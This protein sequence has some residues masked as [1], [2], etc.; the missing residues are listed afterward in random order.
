MCRRRR[1]CRRRPRSR[2]RR[3]TRC[4]RPRRSG[5]ARLRAGLSPAVE[6]RPVGGEANDPIRAVRDVDRAVR[7]HRDG[8]DRGEPRPTARRGAQLAPERAVRAEDLDRVRVLVGDVDRPVRPDGDGLGKAQ[9]A[10][11]SAGR[12]SPRRRTGTDRHP[13]SPRRPPARRAR[14]RTVRSATRSG[15]GGASVVPNPVSRPESR[16][17]RAIAQAGCCVCIRQ[18]RESSCSERARIGRHRRGVL[19]DQK[20]RNEPSRCRRR[21]A[22]AGGC[23]LQRQAGNRAVGRVLARW[24]PPPL[25]AAVCPAPTRSRRRRPTRRSRRFARWGKG[26]R[27]R[28]RRAR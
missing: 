11:R 16:A 26:P 3:R 25:P 7:R 1:R 20:R 23:M 17:A 4:R 9:D 2:R 18:G 14:E 22:L 13:D 6:Q 28:S 15:P 21:R 19:A 12:S 8:A 27:R 10:A 5:T 24:S